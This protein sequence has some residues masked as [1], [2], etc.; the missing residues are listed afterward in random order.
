MKSGIGQSEL[1]PAALQK[2]GVA[3]TLFVVKGAGHGFRNRPDLDPMVN[4]IFAKHMKP[5]GPGK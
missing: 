5:G 1:P 2:A 3:S 4:G